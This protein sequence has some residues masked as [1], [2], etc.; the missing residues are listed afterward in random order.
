MDGN[1][2]RSWSL[3]RSLRQKY[4]PTLLRTSR[5]ALYESLEARQL[6]SASSLYNDPTTLVNPNPNYFDAFGT[7]AVDSGRMVVG[8][9]NDDTNGENAGAAYLYLKKDSPPIAL[10][11]P[12]AEAQ[13]RF[14]ASV[15]ISGT[16]IAIAESGDEYGEHSPSP[17][18][19]H[20]YDIPAASWKKIEHPE[21]HD[22]SEFGAEGLELTNDVLLVTSNNLSTGTLAPSKVYALKPSDGSVINTFSLPGPQRPVVSEID[23]DGEWVI[24]GSSDYESIYTTTDVGRAYLWNWKTGKSIT[25]SNPTPAEDD[26]FGE[27]VALSGSTVVISAP[28]DDANGTDRGQV[29][30]YNFDSSKGSVTTHATMFDPQ[31]HANLESLPSTPNSDFGFGQSVETDG[32]LI[33]AG[34]TMRSRG[35]F[36]TTMNSNITVADSF[37]FPIE[38][39]EVGQASFGNASPALSYID[40]DFLYL[41]GAV[42]YVSD[43]FDN[44]GIEVVIDESNDRLHVADRYDS[45]GGSS[46]AGSL[47]IYEQT[48][49]NTFVVNSTADSAGLTTND[50]GSK[51]PTEGV[52]TLRTAVSMANA[53]GED[54]LIVLSSG[55][56]KLDITG[57]GNN[58]G[59]LDITGEMK[60]LGT[61]SGHSIIDASGLPGERIF[62][63][64]GSLELTGVTLTGADLSDGKNGL[65]GGAIWVRSM[66][67]LSLNR[68]VV[69]G[70]T[71][72]SI[73]G[74]IYNAG[75]LTVNESVISQNISGSSGGGIRNV[76]TTELNRSIVARNSGAPDGPDLRGQFVG[77]AFN[78]RT[79]DV[80]SLGLQGASRGGVDLIVTEFADNAD[81][82]FNPGDLSLREAILSANAAGGPVTIWVPA[83]HHYLTL[84]GK[85]DRA[86]DLDVSGEVTIVGPGAGAAI[87]DASKLTNERHFDVTGTLT[88]SGVT[89][90]GANITQGENGTSG[91]A[92]WVRPSGTFNLVKSAITGNRA[93]QV[94]GAIYNAGT[95]N[96][97]YSVITNN[98]AGSL[99]GGIRSVGMT[100]IS[101]SIVGKNSASW[102][103]EDVYG[104]FSSNGTNHFSRRNGTESMPYDR[105]SSPHYIVTSVVDSFDRTDD[106]YALSLREAVADS[107][108]YTSY[109]AREIWVPAWHFHLTID[110]EG[111]VETGTMEVNTRL[112]VRGTSPTKTIVDATEIQD[113]AFRDLGSWFNPERMRVIDG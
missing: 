71:A 37:G 34:S 7:V 68:S 21:P 88:L 108:R 27:S 36:S 113:K 107:T 73:G 25:I 100:T 75:K 106:Q 76:G 35:Y 48:Y 12:D 13:D 64:M 96:V 57:S 110:G 83:G 69:T 109:Y 72:G 55:T 32:S 6:L 39:I 104:N 87:I 90:T 38:T 47:H 2:K 85:G 41:P 10:F 111:G 20:L 31:Q 112:N 24:I 61:G 78:M 86:G 59:D 66:G 50:D 95:A 67:Q 4:K 97:S 15:A 5:R 3:R 80:G 54:S 103:G 23:V 30:I 99:G 62:D 93:G 33:W 29:H 43:D 26:F 98:R 8:V 65:G 91:G 81:A 92:V 49:A 42:S 58:A 84:T 63:V 28:G 53:A 94:G 19:I 45:A 9:P 60:I 105:V 46:A 14:G 89:L 18:S 102:R 74:G 40:G 79:S 22:F 44:L 1:W 51:V 70:N 52:V 17:G 101:N 16:A 77:N 82:K 56:H 11:S